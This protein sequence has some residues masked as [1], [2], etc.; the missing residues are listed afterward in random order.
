MAQYTNTT[1]ALHKKPD[2]SFYL[3]WILVTFLSIPLAFLLDLVVLHAITRFVGD[4]IYVNGVQHITE[5]YLMVYTFVPIMGILTGALQYTLLQRYL[6]RMGWWIPA[7]IGGWLLGMLLVA[8]MTK[9][10]WRGAAYN[11]DFMFITMGFSIG[12]GQWLLLQRRLPQAG[13]WILANVAGW[14]LLA[15]ITTGN[16]INQ[17]GIITLGLIP[18]CVTAATLALL[19]K[20]D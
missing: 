5:D 7:T 11:L 16:S 3:A 15:L 4:F 8:M 13:W 18:A 20:H 14:G 6:P 17:Y 12:M 9:F 10:V 19:M 2:W 1:G